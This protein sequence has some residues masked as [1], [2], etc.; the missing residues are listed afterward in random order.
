[1]TRHL[2]IAFQTDKT[3]A[4][5]R[6]L[7]QLVSRYG[8]DAVSV[9]ADLPFQPSYVPLHLMAPYLA[10]ERMG[11]ACVCPSRLTPLDMANET[12]LLDHA[13]NGRAYLGI[14]RGAWLER[15]GVREVNPPVTAIREALEIV[16]RLLRG[17]DSGYDGEVYQLEPGVRIG[18]PIL[19][20]R[21]P[22][23]VGTWGPKLAS[24]AGELADEV[25]IGGCANPDMVPL[26]RSWLAEG[27]R[28]A[29]RPQGSVGIV[30][31]AV[32]VVDADGRAAKHAV[33]RDL[34]VYLPAVA[35]LDKTVEIEPALLARIQH[36]VNVG[37]RDT[38]AALISDD[39]LTKFAIAGTPDDVIAQSH[40]LFAAGA[41]RIEFGTP[42]GLQPQQGIK[43]LGERVLPALRQS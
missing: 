33:K 21:V 5:Y 13:T 11:P 15:H 28:V 35:G 8:F 20:D 42:H 43:L 14:A 40:A 16:Q 30:V 12:A 6:E 26:M 32:C 41:S 22:L 25:K 17:D 3:P 24:I 31:G 10:A 9:Y 4:H 36:A 27:E 37:E 23:L 7:A 34:A 38:A 39:L 18:T 2:S 29:G 1:M 19:R